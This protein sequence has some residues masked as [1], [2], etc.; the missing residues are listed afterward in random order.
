[1]S[2]DGGA[3]RYGMGS[4]R[5]LEPAPRPLPARKPARETVTHYQ[6][7]KVSHDEAAALNRGEALPE[8]P[9]SLGAWAVSRGMGL[10]AALAM[11]AEL[12]ESR[13]MACLGCDLGPVPVRVVRTAADV[14]A[15]CD[16]KRAMVAELRAAG[17]TW[18][19]ARRASGLP[20]GTFNRYW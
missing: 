14:T 16:G 19:E 11:A 9:V 8:T 5:P 13:R 4:R 17:L 12:Y 15:E 20:R 2:A 1:M 3:V 10:A 6:G 7:R 18:G